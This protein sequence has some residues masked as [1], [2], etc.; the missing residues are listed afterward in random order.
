MQAIKQVNMGT[1]PMLGGGPTCTL[2]MDMDTNLKTNT[3][4][5]ISDTNPIDLRLSMAW[6]LIF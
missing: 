4:S 1:N 5:T 6:L 2:Y 3:M